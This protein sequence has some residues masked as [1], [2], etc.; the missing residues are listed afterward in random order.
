[1]YRSVALTSVTVVPLAKAEE[2]ISLAQE[3]GE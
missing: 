2:I 3:Q 1:M